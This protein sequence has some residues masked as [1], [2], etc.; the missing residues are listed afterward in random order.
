MPLV[1][2]Q[3]SQASTPITVLGKLP[4]AS[5]APKGG[6]PGIPGEFGGQIPYSGLSEPRK[7][8]SPFRKLYDE[9][10]DHLPNKS[11]TNTVAGWT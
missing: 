2:H 3:E 10:W 1:S 5:T 4:G 6:A 8:R 11:H 7:V 9:L